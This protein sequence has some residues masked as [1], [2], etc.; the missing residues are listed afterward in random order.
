PACATT[1]LPFSPVRY[2]QETPRRRQTRHGPIARQDASGRK[3][4][5]AERKFFRGRAA[6]GSTRVARVT[7]RRIRLPDL[8]ARRRN[9]EI[10]AENEMSNSIY[11]INSKDF[12]PRLCERGFLY[13]MV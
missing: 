9:G 7:S 10:S 4:S 13:V 11:R 8:R 6:R 5:R 3:K 2:G 1:P 12:L